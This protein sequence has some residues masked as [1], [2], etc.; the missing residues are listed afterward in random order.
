MMWCQFQNLVFP[1]A[2]YNPPLFVIPSA[3]EESIR[4]K[5]FV[6]RCFDR[7]SMTVEGWQKAGVKISSERGEPYLK[8]PPA[9][10]SSRCWPRTRF[11]PT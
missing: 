1:S 6:I 7:L 9:G 4:K 5:W 2:L 10:Q 3:V 8:A 11:V